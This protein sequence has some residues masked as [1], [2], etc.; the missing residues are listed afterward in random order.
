MNSGPIHVF[1]Q[2][3]VLLDMEGHP[4]QELAVIE[5]K[6]VINEI[7]DVFHGFTYKN[8][9][10]LD[11]ANLEEKGSPY[12]KYFIATF[13]FWLHFKQSVKIFCNDAQKETNVLGPY[14]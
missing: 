11:K 6:S 7:M 8:V 1:C 9:H 3:H 10:G 5:V 13:M 4:I 12:E 2:F 14:S